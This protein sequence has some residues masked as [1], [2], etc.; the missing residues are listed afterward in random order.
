MTYTEHL[1][2]MDQ[3][4]KLPI[5]YYDF[6]KMVIVYYYEK[7]VISNN[8]HEPYDYFKFTYCQKIFLKNFIFN[9]AVRKIT[10]H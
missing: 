10:S 6:T 7:V 8:L 9:D 4:L 5:N 2:T 3:P 1:R